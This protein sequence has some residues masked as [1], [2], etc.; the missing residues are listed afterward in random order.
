MRALMWFRSDLRVADNTALYHAGKAAGKGVVAVFAVCPKQWAD[1]DW[2]NT[3]VDFVLRSVAA[4][5]AELAKRNIPLLLVRADR[6]AEIPAKL[7]E[8]AKQH[9]CHALY[10]N[11]EYEI[12]E[13]R[14]DR[15]VITLFERHRLAVHS[16]CD[17]VIVDVGRL[18]T[19]AGDP[20]TVFTPF[21]RKW[22]SLLKEEGPP[23][24]WPK[25][26]RQEQ[27]GIPSH[28]V[29]ETLEGFSPR[30]CGDLWPASE[31]A[32][33]RRLVQFVAKHIGQYHKTRDDPG[34][35]GTSE[36]SPYLAAGVLSPRQCLYAA[37]EANDGRLDSGRK[38]V[39][40]WIGELVWREFYR[41]ILHHFPHVCMDRPF[42]RETDKLPW[43]Y[44]EEQFAAWCEGRTGFPIVDA[45]MR[46]LA[47][48]GWMHNRL[49]MIV[50]MFLTKNLFIDW[51]WG[52]RH[53]M[54]QLVDGD[55]ANNNGGWQ[56]SASTG[57][58]AA[59]Y[60][61]VFNPISQSRRCDPG[62]GF[63]RRFVPEL[64]ELPADQI[65]CPPEQ[66]R[67]ALGYPRPI[68]DHQRTRKEAIEAF[69]RL[70]K[71]EA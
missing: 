50:A 63:I 25:I 7:L 65:H 40:T 29:P 53:F 30:R 66:R 16:Y 10:L 70:W 41:H 14:R 69:R 71:K 47:E 18:Q 19:A 4:L 22:C 33:H 67:K 21:R 13:Q 35:G 55:F 46:Q 15:E 51:R 8:V 39:T 61:R 42:K 45:G 57:T 48:T 12:N 36:L 6:F 27:L 38:G 68:V 26:G 23:R 58:D 44:D 20:Y 64:A 11:R 60:F 49:R 2:G 52:Q 43:R 37:L 3:K 1:H 24:L 17:Q 56:W 32:A 31:R 9:S 5:S 34:A 54:K 59:P 62:G 28:T